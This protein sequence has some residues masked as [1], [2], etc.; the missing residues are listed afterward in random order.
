MNFI[1]MPLYAR[2][3]YAIGL[4]LLCIPVIKLINKLNEQ[5]DE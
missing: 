4:G 1:E 5:S 2:A 3:L